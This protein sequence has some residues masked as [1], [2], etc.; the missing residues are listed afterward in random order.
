MIEL[1]PQKKTKRNRDKTKK[2]N[3]TEM[4]PEEMRSK[5]GQ[6]LSADVII[7]II[8]I[9]IIYIYIYIESGG[10]CRMGMSYKWNDDAQGRRDCCVG[11]FNHRTGGHRLVHQQVESFPSEA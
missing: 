1:D 2:Q 11:K 4:G 3:E 7:I 8:F 5:V 10:V 9:I 6:N